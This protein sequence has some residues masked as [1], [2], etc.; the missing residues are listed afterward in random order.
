[1][2]AKLR[3]K[4]WRPFKFKNGRRISIEFSKP[5][6]KHAPKH[7]QFVRKCYVHPWSADDPEC[8]SL[9]GKPLVEKSEWRDLPSWIALYQDRGQ[10][11]Y[12]FYGHRLKP[13]RAD[14][15]TNCYKCHRH[16]LPE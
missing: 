13:A 14:R 16:P 5:L 2:V 3:C 6:R 15:R 11:F 8:E 9:E 1:M 4:L 10:R 12:C 7:A